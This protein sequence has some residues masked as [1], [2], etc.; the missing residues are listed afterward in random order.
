MY[1]GIDVGATKIQGISF[2]NGKIVESIKEMT[3]K[4]PKELIKQ[5][6]NICKK[7]IKENKKIEGIGLGFPGIIERKEGKIIHLP[8]LPKIKNIQIKKILEKKFKIPIKIENDGKCMAISEFLFGE[9]KGKKNIVTLTLG[10]GIGGGIIINK[11]VYIGQGSAGE[12]GHLTLDFKGYKCNCG[13]LGCFEEYAASRAI[14]RFAREEKMNTEVPLEIENLARAGNK[15]AIKVYNRIGY[16]LGIGIGTII[17]TL[18]PEV[19]VLSGGLAHAYDL[20]IKETKKEMK[21]RVHFKTCDIK[22]SKLKN[23]PAIGAASLFSI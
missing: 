8:S 3:S 15:K 1:I 10:T 6:I 9:G 23:A 7:L 2:E 13:R 18:D 5:I 12:L 14:K 21:K 20:F 22:I 16:Y 4:E 17:K 11:K 19:V